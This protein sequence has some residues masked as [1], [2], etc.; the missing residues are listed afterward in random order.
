VVE[1]PA[2]V[3][4]RESYFRWRFSQGLALDDAQ[5]V[6]A[7]SLGEGAWLLAGLPLAR[8]EAWIQMS[9]RLG[10]PIH[11]LVP[12]WLWLYNRLAPFQETPGAL[13]SLSTDH[14]GLYTGTLAAWGRSLVLLRQWADP[15]PMDV[16]M[17]ERVLPSVAFL[18]REGRPPQHLWVWGTSSWPEG[19]MA[20]HLLQPEIP[21]QETL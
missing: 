12:R 3:E 4:A 16:W 7:L 2:G 14:E 15:A 13:I 11:A 18:Q 5:S 10:R 8:R 9:L 21:A 6:Q 1:L 19:P 20:T 17:T